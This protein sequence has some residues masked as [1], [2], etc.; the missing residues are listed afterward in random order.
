MIKNFFVKTERIKSKV[1]GVIKYLKYLEDDKDSRHS[2][3]EIIKIHNLSRNFFNICNKNCTNLDYQNSSRGGRK[4]ESYAQSFDFSFPPNL[5]VSEEDYK[6]FSLK[7]IQV[8][9]NNFQNLND[10]EIFMNVHKNIKVKENESPG[11]L[12][13]LVS[14]VS[15]DKKNN[16]YI[17][18]Y[19]LDQKSICFKLKQE[20]NLFIVNKYNLNPENYVLKKHK[21]GVNKPL[22]LARQEKNAEIEKEIIFN[23]SKLN[24]IKEDINNY[25]EEFN[26]LN[27][28]KNDLEKEVNKLI[29]DIET[30]D[31]KAKDLTDLIKKSNQN[32]NKKLIKLKEDIDNLK[33]EK[34][35]LKEFEE[36]INQSNLAKIIDNAGTFIDIVKEKFTKHKTITKLI[37]EFEKKIT[38]QTQEIF[39]LTNEKEEIKTNSLQNITNEKNNHKKEKEKIINDFE[40]K[41][42]LKDQIIEILEKEIKKIDSNNE[43][44]K[45]I[46][47]K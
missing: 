7:I 13:L 6:E 10:N 33:K 11:H 38:K 2:N 27:I 31:K 4:V 24:T 46:K 40:E 1:E 19:N 29:L 39:E 23:E 16:K 37:E 22:F 28:S 35:S 42:E 44:I 12:N 8:L 5:E 21:K 9:K 25:K 20:F 14:R 30:K 43:I 17:N 3:N 18:N 47:I 36:K 41:I 34:E 45:K 15:F 26:I 32:A